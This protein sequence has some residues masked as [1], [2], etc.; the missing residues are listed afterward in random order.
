MRLL[1]LSLLLLALGGVALTPGMG[2][3]AAPASAP[4]SGGWLPRLLALLPQPGQP[5]QLMEWEAAKLVVNEVAAVGGDPQVLREIVS[6]LGRGEKPQYDPRLRISRAAFDRYLTFEPSLVPT[7]KRLKL[8]VSRE[9]TRLRFGDVAGL[10][11]V[12]K[13][14]E[15]DLSNGELRT[16]EGFA[17]RPRAFVAATVQEHTLKVQHGFE[18]NLRGNDPY[19][20]NGV[21]ATIQ[22]LQLTKGQILLSVTR[23]SML[24]G[25]ITDGTVVVQYTR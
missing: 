24:R 14:I 20:Q 12:L 10:D 17:S 3:G 18:W 7:S 21:R 8:P 5:A 23:F 2:V 16:N 9:G 25:A 6:Q 15:I 19:T 13:G 1:R 22:L 4:L 11:G